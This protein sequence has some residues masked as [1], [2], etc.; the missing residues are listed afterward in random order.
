MIN[1]TLTQDETISR[2]R[3]S[4][5]KA[6]A[7]FLQNQIGEAVLNPTATTPSAPGVRVIRTGGNIARSGLTK[8]GS[9]ANT[10]KTFTANPRLKHFIPNSATS[11]AA[12]N[13][14][15][16]DGSYR[17]TEEITLGTFLNGDNE[18]TNL[19]AITAE[20]QG[21]MLTYLYVQAEMLRAA[22][23]RP[24][25]Q[26][27][28]VN[29]EE[30]I[31]NYEG[32]ETRTEGDLADYSAYGRAIAYNVIFSEDGAKDYRKTFELAEYWASLPWYDKIICDYHN[33]RTD[34][35]IALR[36]FLVL[37]ELDTAFGG[38]WGRKLE[39]RWNG[40]TQS[41]TLLLL[42]LSGKSALV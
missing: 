7:I 16:I 13:Y 12:E 21:K 28:K 20:D 36:I 8:L 23:E 33:Y 41:E 17:L 40:E 19:D 2:L 30:G 42:D 10:S 14:D 39:T 9:G 32:V 15:D 37:P 24:E 27:Y 18:P 11:Q 22:R 35:S 6:S 5:L 1:R 4:S 31:Y 29:V 25:F 34:G 3:N 26:R 38:S